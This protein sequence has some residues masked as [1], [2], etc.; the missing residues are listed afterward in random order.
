MWLKI[1]ETSNSQCSSFIHVFK[2]PKNTV[3]STLKL[4]ITCGNHL[5][6]KMQIQPSYNGM[7]KAK[8]FNME[9]RQL[10]WFSDHKGFQGKAEAALEPRSLSSRSP[11]RLTSSVSQ[12]PHEDLWL[13]SRLWPASRGIHENHGIDYHFME[14]SQTAQG[15]NDSVFVF[16][17]KGKV[18]VY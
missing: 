14:I 2:Y 12:L 4:E 8:V 3:V 11:H 17:E 9:V 1:K 18:R 10:I 7:M 13:H 6:H 16:T 5:V 15:W